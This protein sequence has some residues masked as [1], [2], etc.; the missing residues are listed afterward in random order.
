[1][2]WRTA[3]RLNTTVKLYHLKEVNHPHKTCRI[4]C[5]FVMMATRRRSYFS[6]TQM[7]VIESKQQTAICLLPPI[8][9]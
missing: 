1:M 3:E 5:G 7:Q 8:Y 2:P 9:K 6:G 4:V